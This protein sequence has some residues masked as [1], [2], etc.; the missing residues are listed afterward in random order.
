[1]HTA[2]ATLSA[3]ASICKQ[4]RFSSPRT[5]PI[6]VRTAQ[7]SYDTYKEWGFLGLKSLTNRLQKGVAFANAKGILF[8]IFGVGTG[9]G[10]SINFGKSSFVY[11]IAGHDWTVGDSLAAVN[12]T[13]IEQRN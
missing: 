7:Y 10:I 6:W 5:E 9:F 1:M 12:G 8:P 3:A 13:R 11:D 4:G 2:K